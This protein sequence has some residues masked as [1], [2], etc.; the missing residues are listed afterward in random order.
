MHRRFWRP[1]LGGAEAFS[2]LITTSFPNT[3]IQYGQEGK[4]IF[5]K[6]GKFQEN[7][8]TNSL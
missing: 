3:L 1:F 2:F 4:V 7:I 6:V 5:T 8:G